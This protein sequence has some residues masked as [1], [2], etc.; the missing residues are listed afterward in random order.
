MFASQK[1]VVTGLHRS[2][3]R[4]LGRVIQKTGEVAALHEP[5]NKAY[6][7]RGVSEWYPFYD[8]CANSPGNSI[9]EELSAALFAGEAQYQ[10]QQ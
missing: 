5:F 9:I 7:M 1:F 6:G 2:G 4:W 3:T 10:W 8:L